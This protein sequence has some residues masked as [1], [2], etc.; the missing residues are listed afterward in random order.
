NTVVGTEKSEAG[1]VDALSAPLTSFSSDPIR[2]AFGLGVGNASTSPLGPQFTGRYARTYGIFATE[3]SAATFLVETGVFGLA[4]ILLLHYLVLQ[5]AMFVV[6]RDNGLMGA[7]ACGWVGAWLVITL[8]NFYIAAHFLDAGSYIPWFFSGLMAA[9][10]ERLS[11]AFAEE[12]PPVVE[13]Q[14]PAAR[15]LGSQRARQQA[16]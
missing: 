11:A 13:Q 14:A 10:R 7:L 8:G 2:L 9:K 12:S 1:R 3:T 15:A 4:L 6:R 5:D 16:Q